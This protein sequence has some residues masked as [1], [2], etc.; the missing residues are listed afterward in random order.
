MNLMVAMIVI[1]SDND[2]ANKS[3]KSDDKDNGRVINGNGNDDDR[4]KVWRW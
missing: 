4:R 2:D 3:N 1:N